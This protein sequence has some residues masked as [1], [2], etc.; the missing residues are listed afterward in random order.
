LVAHI[1]IVACLPFPPV[2]PSVRPAIPAAIISIVI[3]V[4]YHSTV[5]SLSL[6]SLDQW[7][8]RTTGATN[9]GICYVDMPKK[10]CDIDTHTQEHFVSLQC[11]NVILG[12]YET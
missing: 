6:L 10:E 1:F 8:A 5:P 4:V 3:L 9:Q 11:Q 12:L 2:H 7:D